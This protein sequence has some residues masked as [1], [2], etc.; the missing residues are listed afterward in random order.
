MNGVDDQDLLYY[1]VHTIDKAN[2]THVPMKTFLEPAFLDKLNEEQ[3]EA[4]WSQQKKLFGDKN[5]ELKNEFLTK[6]E[7]EPGIEV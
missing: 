3:K 2:Y 7:N 6:S 1:T 5:S 4:Y